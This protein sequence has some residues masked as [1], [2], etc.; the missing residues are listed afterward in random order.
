M[1]ALWLFHVSPPSEEMNNPVFLVSTMANI[2]LGS[3][4]A[5]FIAIRPNGFSGN[6][7]LISFHVFPPSVL[8]YRPLPLPPELKLKGCLRNCHMDA[9][10]M[11][12][13]VGS[14]KISAQPVSL[15]M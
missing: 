1:V 9:N 2:C 14:I 12:G 13:F 5:K 15:S 6:P 4:G 3:L 11:L 10:R 8:L 7:F